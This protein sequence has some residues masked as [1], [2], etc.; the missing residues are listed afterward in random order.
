MSDRWTRGKAPG[1]RRYRRGEPRRGR[2]QN[3]CRASASRGQGAPKCL[4]RPKVTKIFAD[5][6]NLEGMLELCRDSR[7]SGFTTNPTLMHRLALSTMRALPTRSWRCAEV[8][9]SFEVFSDDL[10]EMDS[11]ARK[12]AG[13]GPNV[14]VKIPVTNTRRRPR[15]LIRRLSDEGIRLNVTASTIRQV[16]EMARALN[17]ESRLPS[18][19]CS[20]DASPTPAR[21]R[22]LL[23]RRHLDPLP[24]P[25]PN[26]M[27]EPAGTPQFRGR[28]RRSDVTSSR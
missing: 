25:S 15:Q 13:W 17:R 23:W 22:C 8:P 18:F 10:D 4:F 21:I 24:K 26:S 3:T 20:P 6:A 16:T 1:G 27:G 11:Q 5:G 14:Y 12:I 2:S 9:V 28:P 7:I 19:R